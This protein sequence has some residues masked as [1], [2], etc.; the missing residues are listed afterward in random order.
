MAHAIRRGPCVWTNYH[1]TASCQL[2]DRIELWND[3]APDG[4]TLLRDAAV[5]IQSVLRD[6]KAKGVTVRAV[7]SAWSPAPIALSPDGWQLETSRMNRTFRLAAGDL[8]PAHAAD[9]GHMMLAQCG[10]LIDE[11]ND[12]AEKDLGRSLRTTGASNGQTVAGAFATGTHGS[13][14]DAGGIQDH[15]RA[16]QVVTPSNVW[17]IEPSEGFLSDAFVAA[18]GAKPLRD[19]DAFSAAQVS[20]G[21]IGFVAAV[22]IETAPRYLVEVL[23]AK[24]VVG[25]DAIMMLCEGRFREFSAQFGRDEEPYFVQVIVNPYRPEKGKGLIKMMYR[26]E[27]RPDYPHAGPAA[28][29]ASYDTLSLLGDLIERFPFLRGW[30]LQRV[31]ELSYPDGP[32][33]VEPLPIGTW[34]EMT[35]THTPL[36]SL[37]N[38]SVTIARDDLSRAFRTIVDAYASGGG[39]NSVTVRFMQRAQG[40]LA[41]ARFAHNAV[42]DFDGVRSSKSTE[43]YRRVTAALDEAQ[44]PFGRHW[45]K[46]NLLDAARVRAD[47]GDALTR[48]LAAQARIMPDGGDRL[49]FYNPELAHLGLIA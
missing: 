47:Y 23:Q 17:W 8:V 27:W 10:T 30:L 16:I 1:G 28:L 9:A 35:E 19:D 41:P 2:S 43:S 37:F 12:R 34:G 11:I 39:G 36:G 6:A 7:G 31:M 20:V 4:R 40:L 33:P 38:G 3:D 29:G 21:S 13:V 48:W 26:R 24:R 32:K 18:C 14:L 25:H 46:T 45:A 5:L 44:I 15:L 22:V 42:I 49:L